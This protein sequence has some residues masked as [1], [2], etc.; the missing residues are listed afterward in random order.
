MVPVWVAGADVGVGFGERVGAGVGVGVG[1][2]VGVGMGVGVEEG[3]D[4]IIGAGE[5]LGFVEF[6]MIELTLTIAVATT[7]KMEIRA[8]INS[9]L[10][11][12][13]KSSAYSTKSSAYFPLRC[14]KN[15]T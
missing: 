1:E 6:T 11:Y 10:Y 12:S 4:E 8:G 14:L 13:S 2:G 9:I 5:G 7:I 15:S 3:V